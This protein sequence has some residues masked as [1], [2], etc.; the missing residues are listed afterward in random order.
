[1]VA[2]KQPPFYPTDIHDIQTAYL[3]CGS[4]TRGR[5]GRAGE[6]NLKRLC[7]RMPMSKEE[8]QRWKLWL[9]ELWRDVQKEML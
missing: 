6:G 2:S 9:R 4:F 8:A 7:G 1:M 5:L 3:L